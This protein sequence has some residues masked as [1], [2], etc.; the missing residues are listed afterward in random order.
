MAARAVASGRN[1]STSCSRCRRSMQGQD[2]GGGQSSRDIGVLSLGTCECCASERAAKGGLL[3]ARFGKWILFGETRN[4]VAVS[5]PT[6]LR[7]HM[8]QHTLHEVRIE[9]DAELA[10]DSEKQRVRGFDRLVF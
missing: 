10:R 6:K 5:A 4:R 9:V 3:L 1:R 8:A 2:R 7:R